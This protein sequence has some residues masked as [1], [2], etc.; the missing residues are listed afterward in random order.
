MHPAP[1]N[2]ASTSLCLYASSHAFLPP[3]TFHRDRSLHGRD[4]RPGATRLFR[5]RNANVSGAPRGRQRS[6]EGR[7]GPSEASAN[8]WTTR[9]TRA[10]LSACTPNCESRVRFAS[11]A[12]YALAVCRTNTSKQLWPNA[13]PNRARVPS[14]GRAWSAASRSLRGPLDE[15]RVAS[16]YRSLLRAGFSADTIRRELS[17]VTKKSMEELPE[18]SGEEG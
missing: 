6:G 2:L 1:C 16:L 12:I 9:G 4:Q 10:S 3:K 17:A 7:P 11:R 14:C 8:I 15:R 5:L 13:L 18:R